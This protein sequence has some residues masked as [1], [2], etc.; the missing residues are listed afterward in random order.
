MDKRIQRIERDSSGWWIYLSAGYVG[1]D[2]DHAICEDTKG[3]AMKKMKDVRTCTC[4]DCTA[5]PTDRAIR[6]AELS[7]QQRA[8]T[9]AI[10]LTLP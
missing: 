7:R 10:I 9:A 2:G 1:A 8:Q 6:D 5:G 4:S 3:A